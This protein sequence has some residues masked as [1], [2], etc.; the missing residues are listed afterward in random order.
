MAPE[1]EAQHDDIAGPCSFLVQGLKLFLLLSFSCAFP[2]V[3]IRLFWFVPRGF[4]GANRDKPKRT[5][6]K[7]RNRRLSILSSVLSSLSLSLSFS[8]RYM[9]LLRVVCNM[10][11]P[12]FSRFAPG[13]MGTQSGREGTGEKF[14][15]HSTVSLLSICLGF[16]GFWPLGLYPGLPDRRTITWS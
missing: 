14:L 4:L 6:K 2:W 10:H 11:V 9:W 13:I 15:F 7:K 16:L 8:S 12:F 3:V 5:Q 1:R